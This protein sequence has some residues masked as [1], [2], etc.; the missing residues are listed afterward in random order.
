MPKS[1]MNGDGNW[2]EMEIGTNKAKDAGLTEVVDKELVWFRGV[3]V[4]YL[5]HSNKNTTPSKLKEAP[6]HINNSESINQKDGKVLLETKGLVRQGKW[7]ELPEDGKE[8]VERALKQLIKLY[9]WVSKRPE[10]KQGDIAFSEEMIVKKTDIAI[11]RD[12]D[13]EEETS[14]NNQ[15]K[16]EELHLKK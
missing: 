11:A 12:K 7:S 5:V 9:L 13:V 16:E 8:C 14:E 2:K 1:Q 15:L 10:S 3:S 6:A 4:A